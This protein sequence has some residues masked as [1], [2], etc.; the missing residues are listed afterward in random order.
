VLRRETQEDNMKASRLVC[1][2]A[3]LVASS[4]VLGQNADKNSA[5]P[6][7]ND[8]RL[9]VI[10]PAEG[11]TIAGPT[12]RVVVAIG[13]KLEPGADRKDTDTMPKPT[14]QVFVDNQLKGVLADP[15]N[16]LEIQDVT[17]GPHKLAIVATNQSKEIIDRKEV[18]FV[19]TEA[20]ASTA[21][22][23]TSSSSSTSS[24]S[25]P[26]PAPSTSSNPPPSSY[27]SSTSPSTS[28]PSTYSS[29]TSEKSTS[30]MTSDTNASK[31]LPKT[32]SSAPLVAA[33]GLG[34]LALGLAT[35]PRA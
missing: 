2:A 4:I 33:A 3:M 32:G 25:A 21:T 11:A 34:L 35:R 15:Q 8:Y 14:V 26:A 18:S 17:P 9:K 31:R 20:T 29:S 27:S 24:Y 12:V 23:S 7:K 16:V 28:A 10:E 6:T 19:S 30:T 1:I 13:T 22:S 5:G